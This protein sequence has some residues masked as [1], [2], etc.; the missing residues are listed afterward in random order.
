M[1]NS[2]IIYKKNRKVVFDD[3]PNLKMYFIHVQKWWTGICFEK[4]NTKT[5]IWKHEFSKENWSRISKEL[6]AYDYFY[7][8]DY[9]DTGIMYFSE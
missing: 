6:V 9:D 8:D 4:E 5:V 1:D 7:K 2:I 3:K